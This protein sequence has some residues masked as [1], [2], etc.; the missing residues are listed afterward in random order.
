VDVEQ[1]FAAQNGVT[2]A[3]VQ[4]I[5]VALAIVAVDHLAHK[6]YAAHSGV[7]VVQAQIIVAGASRLLI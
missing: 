3:Q 5:V 2:V 4:S 1:E 7:T 6:A